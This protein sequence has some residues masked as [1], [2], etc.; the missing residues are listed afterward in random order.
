MATTSDVFDSFVA[1]FRCF[2]LNTVQHET[3]RSTSPFKS[4]SFGL[5]HRI[6]LWQGTNI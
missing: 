4:R 6:V 1:E 2:T 5:W 3:F